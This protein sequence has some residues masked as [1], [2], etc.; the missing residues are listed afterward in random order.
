MEGGGG[1]HGG[2][3]TWGEEREVDVNWRINVF[4]HVQLL[5]GSKM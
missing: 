5:N 1:G 3:G 2:G 4:S